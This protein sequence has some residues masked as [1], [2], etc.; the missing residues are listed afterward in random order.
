M[1]SR[2][3]LA[4]MV[5]VGLLLMLPPTVIA[6]S[7][8]PH[9]F[10]GTVTVNGLAAGGIG[11]IALIDGE[12]LGSTTTVS[13]GNYTLHVGYPGEF[14]GKTIY[15]VLG[16]SDSGRLLA[17]QTALWQQGSATRLNLTG[18][19]TAEVPCPP[20][21]IAKVLEAVFIASFD[22]NRA[23]RLLAESGYPDGFACPGF[24]FR[25][26]AAVL[27]PTPTPAPAPS[28]TPLP[29]RAPTPVQQHPNSVLI[30]L[31][32][33]VDTSPFADT[34]PFFAKEELRQAVYLSLNRDEYVL[35]SNVYTQKLRRKVD[36]IVT[37]SIPNPAL[38]WELDLSKAKEKMA[39]EGFPDGFSVNIIMDKNVRRVA[40]VVAMH[41]QALGLEVQLHWLPEREL[42]RRIIA[43]EF[44]L[45]VTETKADP[46]NPAELL[47]RLLLS[48]GGENY[49]HFQS[50]E[51]DRLFNSGS[52]REA[53][54]V[55][56]GTSPSVVPLVW[57]L[58]EANCPPLADARVLEAARIAST[59]PDRAGQLLAEAGY[60]DGFSCPGYDLRP[61]GTASARLDPATVKAKAGD[62]F[63]LSIEVEAAVRGVSGGE[64]L[65][66]FPASVLE[67][68]S[69]EPGA[70]LGSN[71]VRGVKEL[72]STG[73]AI[74]LA[75]ARQGASQAP[76]APGSFMVVRFRVRPDVQPGTYQIG[77]KTLDLSDERFLALMVSPPAP[78]TLRLEA[79]EALPGDTNG[80]NMVDH[81]DLAMLGA[82]YG[83]NRD[84]PGFSRNVDFNQDGFIDYRDLAILGANY[85]R[86]V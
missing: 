86:S 45:F 72:D 81:R 2:K 20:M 39:L 42:Q 57:S 59:D 3:I 27:G 62:E 80:D 13:D 36:S 4:G 17:Q 58:S 65:L 8:P 5:A 49:T 29:T 54:K 23:R 64:V 84:E 74:R 9:I 83:K 19:R 31:G 71:P 55:A 24:E 50:N 22:P 69:Y 70:L 73:G 40:E 60:P 6:Q 14:Q 48:S 37:P 76:A 15:F 44:D 41:L 46:A 52:Y 34:S 35:V 1:T 51:F 63:M 53:E 47:G 85:G 10:Q 16:A 28:L 78:T 32:M 33:N 7:V 12:K 56:F 25:P 66:S 77:V 82:S 79:L 11:V 75:L 21:A 30:Y 18:D 61:S 68:V 43:G 26:P 38:D 67:V